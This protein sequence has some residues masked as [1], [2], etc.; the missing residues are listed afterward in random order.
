MPDSKETLNTLHSLVFA[1]DRLRQLALPEDVL[2]PLIDLASLVTLRQQLGEDR[3]AFIGFIGC[4]GTGKSTLFN[5]FIGQE[6]SLTGWK[7]HNTCGP[8]LFMADSVLKSL[9][10]WEAKSVPLLLPALKREVHSNENYATFISENIAKGSPDT[11]HIISGPDEKY[12]DASG[13][14]TGPY[15]FIDLPDI[16]SSPALDENLVA[17]EVLPWLD[18][19]IFMVDDE[20]VFHRGY[21]QPVQFTNE[22]EQP[23]FC[24]LSNRGRDRVDLNHPDIKQTMSFFGVDSIHVLPKL[25]DKAF[26]DHE[27]AFVGFKQTIEANRKLA[28][29]KPLV[30]RIAR[31]TQRV[32]EENKKRQQ[33][34]QSLEKKISQMITTTLAEDALV[35]FEKILHDDVL[36]A[37]RH[38][39]LK[40]FAV[41]NLL[42][43]F[44]VAAST[45]SLKHGLKL[46][47]G[48][49]RDK[50]LAPKLRFDREKLAREVSKRLVDYRER[51]LLAIRSHPDIDIIQEVEPVFTA[52]IDGDL[53]TGEEAAT[54]QLYSAELRNIVS[55]FEQECAELLASDSVS[56]VIQNDPLVAVFLVAAFVADV[57]V[58]RGF[59]G[60]LLVPT[61]FRYLPFGKFEAIK[62]SFQHDIQNLIQKQ[63]SLITRELHE[64]RIRT[65]LEDQDPLLQSLKVCAQYGKI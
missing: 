30:K 64:I 4:T 52:M 60:W 37:L 24:A 16:N 26:F 10:Q 62:R 29:P 61:A 63:L 56:K 23:R 50:A 12:R 25:K 2:N 36:Q 15:V 19:V 33:T 34:L 7:V 38:L 11:L 65:V 58:L 28:P 51:I 44:K 35:S 43:F 46:S 55:K 17:L 42:N 6:I 27:P 9:N 47:F 53:Q 31:L 3:P 57:F 21:E 14:E 8:V 1:A 49:R 5:S 20:T 22:L 18:V 40:R 54:S 59:V 41:S 32:I 45:G 48:D 13:P 39:G